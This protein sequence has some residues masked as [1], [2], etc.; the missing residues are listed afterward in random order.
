MRL[1][2]LA[3]VIALP[4]AAYAAVCTQQFTIDSG[5][6]CAER[7]EWCNA[8]IPCCGRLECR[9]NG[10]SSVCLGLRTHLLRPMLDA[11]L[12]TGMCLRYRTRIEE[13]GSDHVSGFH[14]GLT[15]NV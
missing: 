4:A 10:F 14:V 11:E 12:N 5:P 8:E 6:Q 7:G 15:F 1:S 3:F 2:V 9:W 13:K